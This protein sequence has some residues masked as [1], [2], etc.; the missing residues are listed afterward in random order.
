MWDGYGSVAMVGISHQGTVISVIFNKIYFSWERD[1][2]TTPSNLL[3]TDTT[4]YVTYVTATTDYSMWLLICIL[5]I[6][7]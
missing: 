2:D 3:T 7:W 1:T 4:T 5:A 6:D